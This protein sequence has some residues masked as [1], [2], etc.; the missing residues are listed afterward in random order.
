M[1]NKSG[2]TQEDQNTKS[3]RTK[4]TIQSV[5]R[6]ARILRALA[7]GPR[8]LGVTELSDRLGITRPT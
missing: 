8:R 1:P 3:G 7:S 4:G 5:D 2:Q 6:A